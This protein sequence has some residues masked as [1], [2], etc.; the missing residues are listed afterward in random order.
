ME[1]ENTRF[2]I[3]IVGATG[4]LGSSITK[5]CLEKPNLIVNILIRNPDKDPE[6]VSKVEKAGGKVIVGDLLKT[7]T[8]KDCTK[9]MHTVV[10]VVNSLVDERI[11]KDAQIALIDDCV[12][13]GVE[14]FVPSDFGLNYYNLPQ[15]DLA[16]LLPFGNAKYYVHNYLKEK[17][18]KTL[19]ISIG[20]FLES[21]FADPFKGLNYWGD[22]DYKYQLT[23]CDDTG[24]ITAAAVARK[25]LTGDVVYVV[26]KLSAKEIS[27]IYEKV[28]GVK[29]TPK[30]LGSLEDLS[31]KFEEKIQEKDQH[32]IFILG[33]QKILT[34]KR[35]QFDEN[36]LDN[37]PEVH[38]TSFEECLRQN[39]D[40]KIPE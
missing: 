30:R 4:L 15:E 36:H 21:V 38:P 22:L 8:L 10:S 24:K 27:E 17:P 39:P 32:A 9:G 7:E 6:L 25:D 19:Q 35:S 16:K 20:A 2:N 13:N 34:D 3:L 28:R 14:R 26:N 31:K 1:S 33:I 12:K 5:Y 23:T 37:F 29:I 18:I 11:F 40:G